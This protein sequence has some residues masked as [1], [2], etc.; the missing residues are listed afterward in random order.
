MNQLSFARPQTGDLT[1]E[2]ELPLLNGDK[3]SSR[4]LRGKQTLLFFWAS[5]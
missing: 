5:R 3:F 4:S 2:W 1:P